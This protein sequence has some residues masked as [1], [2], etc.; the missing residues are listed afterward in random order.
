MKLYTQE[1]V[2]K[3][4]AMGYDWCHQKQR[5]TMISDWLEKHGDSEIYKKVEERL[6]QITREIKYKEVTNETTNFKTRVMG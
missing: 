6:E 5:N 1:Q 3:A 4:I 2:R